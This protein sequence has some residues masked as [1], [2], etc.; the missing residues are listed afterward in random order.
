MEKKIYKLILVKLLLFLC[1]H[2]Q[3]LCS[4]VP[5]ETSLITKQNNS[6]ENDNNTYISWTGCVSLVTKRISLIVQSKKD[7]KI[8]D[9]N[10]D[11]RKKDKPATIELEE[12]DLISEN[13]VLVQIENVC[14]FNL[15]VLQISFNNSLSRT[16]GH[17]ALGVLRFHFL[18]TQGGDAFRLVLVDL[19]ATLKQD[20]GKVGVKA[21]KYRYFG[22][23]TISSLHERREFEASWENIV[24]H[25]V[26][27]TQFYFKKS[28]EFE[29]SWDL[30]FTW[31]VSN[32]K[33]FFNKNSF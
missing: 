31:I 29:A 22:E 14:N 33:V 2:I 23:L 8:N 32:A 30:F 18:I 1:V 24:K 27:F 12:I 15:R 7:T 9:K 19:D 4:T 11:K 3:C 13:T 17:E 25:K 5:E 10:K 20:G 6:L 26:F 16:G 21:K 28:W